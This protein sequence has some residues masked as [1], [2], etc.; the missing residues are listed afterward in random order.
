MELEPHGSESWDRVF[1][2]FCMQKEKERP[3]GPEG[4]LN[5]NHPQMACLEEKE[6]PD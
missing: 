3:L 4:G 2:N 6:G 5:L 1:Q